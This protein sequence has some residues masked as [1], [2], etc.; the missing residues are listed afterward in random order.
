M[1]ASCETLTVHA[2]ARCATAH[3]V[4]IGVGDG[5]VGFG[6][7]VVKGAVT[8][9]SEERVK[10]RRWETKCLLPFID[11]V[12]IAIRQEDTMLNRSPNLLSTTRSVLTV[13]IVLNAIVFAAFVGVLGLTVLKEDVWLQHV[14][15]G[16]ADAAALLVWIRVVLV[17]GIATLP[18]AHLVFKRL[19]AIVRSVETGSPFTAANAVRLKAI[20]WAVLAI[21]ILDLGFGLASAQTAR[22]GE[23]IGWGPG[24]TGWLAVLL[25]FVLARVFERGAAMEDELAGTV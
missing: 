3:P 19:R 4:S 25:L 23:F 17:I 11:N 7:G 21:Q 8:A 1:P 6:W 13:L 10:G 18:L 15:N 14:G 22:V 9:V 2:E 24:L 5:D 12:L 16:P 20:A